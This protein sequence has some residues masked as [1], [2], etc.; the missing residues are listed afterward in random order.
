MAVAY[1]DWPNLPVN[2]STI[3]LAVFAII[4]AGLDR[5]LQFIK[6]LPH[7]VHW[8]IVSLPVKFVAAVR[9][10]SLFANTSVETFENLVDRLSRSS[11]TALISSL[12][13]SFTSY[14]CTNC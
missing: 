7:L 12:G 4:G 6:S 8:Q 5:R 2:R 13:A 10:N 3:S 9:G 14:K 11:S 1:A